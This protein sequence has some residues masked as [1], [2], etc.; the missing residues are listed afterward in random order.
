MTRLYA[1]P[2]DPIAAWREAVLA[3]DMG[4]RLMVP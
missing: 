1:D 4:G 3:E 2:A